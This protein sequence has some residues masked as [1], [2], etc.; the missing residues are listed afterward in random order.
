MTEQEWLECTDPGRMLEF[1][2]DKASHRKLRLFACA[3]LHA[4]RDSFTD[5]IL[6]DTIAAIEGSGGNLP[7]GRVLAA[8]R[9]A[10]QA[11][12]Q[13]LCDGEPRLVTGDSMASFIILSADSGFHMAQ[14]AEVHALKLPNAS[15]I[16]AKLLREV[17][18]NPFRPVAL[19]L[20]WLTPAGVQLA[21]ALYDARNFADLPILADDLEESGC[22]SRELLDHLR[23][24]GPH[25]LGCW[26][27]DLL[28]NK[29]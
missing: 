20:S 21:Q 28:L 13:S 9:A 8:G 25:V 12:Q 24:P 26:T 17:F 4:Y 19:D 22:T 11:L 5:P 1:L 16:Y 2:R 14:I 18:G 23:E 10:A 29:A 3:C 27:L 15:T 6:R 7:E